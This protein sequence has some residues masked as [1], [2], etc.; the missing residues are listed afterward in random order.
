MR[1]LN[2]I[3]TQKHNRRNKQDGAIFRGQYKSILIDS[4]NYMLI[5]NRYIHL[6]PIMAGM[7]ES[8]ENYKWSSY[9]AYIL[10]ER[11]PDWLYCN[12]TLSYF[13]SNKKIQDYKD[14][15]LSEMNSE[16][17]HF[18]DRKKYSLFWVRMNL[19]KK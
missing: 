15:V 11:K 6:N 4:E 19:S 1:H 3:F 7:V 8:S 5:L 9:N 18:L 17:A 12:E 10:D 16:I 2:G 13:D 14:F